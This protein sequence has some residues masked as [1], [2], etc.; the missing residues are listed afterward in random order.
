MVCGVLSSSKKVAVGGEGIFLNAGKGGRRKQKKKRMC[1]K[2]E[3]IQD[4]TIQIEEM[5]VTVGKRRRNYLKNC[6]RKPIP[7]KCG[8]KKGKESSLT[9]E[10]HGQ[11]TEYLCRA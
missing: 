3:K 6:E 10:Y 9:R 11:A 5:N 2:T 1:Q 8:R 4:N 7:Q